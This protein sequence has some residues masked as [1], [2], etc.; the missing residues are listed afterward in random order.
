MKDKRVKK[1]NEEDSKV[2]IE[3]FEKIKGKTSNEKID[4]FLKALMKVPPPQKVKQV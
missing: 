3:T 4:I 2:I 1:Q